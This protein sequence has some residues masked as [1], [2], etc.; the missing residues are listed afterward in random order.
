RASPPPPKLTPA[1]VSSPP[2]LPVRVDPPAVTHPKLMAKR[3]PASVIP[4]TSSV[5]PAEQDPGAEDAAYLLIVALQR[6]GRTDAARAAAATY[7]TEFPSGFRR[8]EVLRF[9]L[10]SYRAEL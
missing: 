8:P 2:A 3:L 5:A 7:L 10:G 1:P 9:A 6:Q 4:A